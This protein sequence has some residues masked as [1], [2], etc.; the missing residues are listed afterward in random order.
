MAP[1]AQTLP[2]LVGLGAN[3]GDGKR[4]L[5]AAWEALGRVDGLV[6]T[7]LSS[8]Y[9]TAP[10]GMESSHWFTNA[11]GALQSS[12]SPEELLRAMQVVEADFGR[13]RNREA[14]GYQDRT[15][16]LDLLACGELRLATA[17]LVLPHPRLADRLF[18]LVPLVEICP[19]YR[20]N[21]RGLTAAAMLLALRQRLAGA[22]NGGQEIHRDCW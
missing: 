12:L 11:V 15:L 17:E 9:R 20:D 22:G 5:L 10:V 8:P 21:H 3:L 4:T 19:E 2:A 7:A 18:V 14:A 16:D 13:R 6:T 1:P